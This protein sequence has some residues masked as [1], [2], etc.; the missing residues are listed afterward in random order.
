M[1]DLFNI[2]ALQE[3]AA[4]EYADAKERREGEHAV[5]IA[6][7]IEGNALYGAEYSK[8]AR[9]MMGITDAD[10]LYA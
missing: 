4:E 10:Q 7:Y 3:K 2:C 8:R 9:N 6:W 1:R 5:A